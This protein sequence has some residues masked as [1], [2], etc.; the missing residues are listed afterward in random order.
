MASASSINEL[1]IFLKVSNDPNGVLH[2]PFTTNLQRYEAA[3]SGKKIR[4]IDEIPLK[5]PYYTLSQGI[6]IH[7]SSL[8]TK[9]ANR[10]KLNIKLKDSQGFQYVNRIPIMLKHDGTS[11]MNDPEL[12]RTF[13]LLSDHNLRTKNG[14][15]DPVATFDEATYFEHSYFFSTFLPLLKNDF[16]YEKKE[17]K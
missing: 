8:D 4:D 3:S 14:D 11:N 5:V 16:I 7:F 2:T 13:H 9:S 12:Q 10:C 17:K 15:D 6:I 1:K